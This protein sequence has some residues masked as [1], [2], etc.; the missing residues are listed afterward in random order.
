MAG[1]MAFET[2]PRQLSEDLAR[3]FEKLDRKRNLVVSM[4]FV[5]SVIRSFGPMLFDAAAK[6]EAAPLLQFMQQRS[7]Q[8]SAQLPVEPLGRRTD[9]GEVLG[10]GALGA[11]WLRELC[12]PPPKYRW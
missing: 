2:D 6:G 1:G 5:T 8:I 4:D 9:G 11:D 12:P 7:E 10:V 3:V